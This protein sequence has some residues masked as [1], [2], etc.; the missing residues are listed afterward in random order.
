MSSNRQKER[1]N[2]QESHDFEAALFQW[3]RETGERERE[4]EREG[5]EIKATAAVWMTSIH[6]LLTLLS[7]TSLSAWSSLSLSL[8]PFLSSSSLFRDDG[9][10]AK[11]S[12]LGGGGRGRQR[13]RRAKRRRRRRGGPVAR[14]LIAKSPATDGRNGSK[15]GGRA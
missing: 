10:I 11:K 2:G 5:E 14:S 8:S 1:P 6:F 3:N 15:E 12:F 13:R 9:H 7:H 4:R